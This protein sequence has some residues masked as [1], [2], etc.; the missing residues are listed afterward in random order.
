MQVKWVAELMEGV[1]TSD[2][3]YR[4]ASG[5]L[6]IYSSNHTIQ[7]S[8][9][10]RSNKRSRRRRLISQALTILSLFPLSSPS[11]VRAQVTSSIS[12][13]RVY[14]LRH[15]LTRTLVLYSITVIHISTRRP[16]HLAAKQ[17]YSRS[18]ARIVVG[19]SDWLQHLHAQSV[20]VVC[21]VIALARSSAAPSSPSNQEVHQCVAAAPAAELWAGSG[22]DF[23]LTSD[24]SM[25]R[26]CLTALI[27][28]PCAS[29]HEHNEIYV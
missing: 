26:F 20:S 19:P 22:S 9:H 4:L 12:Q 11:K 5:R 21:A 18:T 7:P 10:L 17:T 25:C 28:V 27:G 29:V 14:L 24:N 15:H 13:G 8:T 23:N 2:H 3:P 16:R 1:L 6:A